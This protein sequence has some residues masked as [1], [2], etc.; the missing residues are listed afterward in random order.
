MLPNRLQ[1]LL[2]K[3]VDWFSHS[4]SGL[5]GIGGSWIIDGFGYAVSLLQEFCNCLSGLRRLISN[6]LHL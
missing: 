5:V 3:A 4:L 2:S 6:N 1:R